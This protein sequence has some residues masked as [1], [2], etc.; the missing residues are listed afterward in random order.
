MKFV[1]IIVALAA[2]FLFPAASGLAQEQQPVTTVV[3]EPPGDNCPAGGVKVTVT[4]APEPDPEPTP[5][6]TETPT[7]DPTETATPEPTLTAVAAQAQEPEVYY[8]C[9]GQSGEPGPD[10]QDGPD[11]ANGLD[12]TDGV[13]GADGMDGENASD[14]STSPKS[15]V[16]ASAGVKWMRVPARFKRHRKVTVIANAKRRHVRVSARHKVRVDLR[17]AACGYYPVLVRKRGIRPLLRIWHLT[18][19]SARVERL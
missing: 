10:G 16:C 5:D 4:P 15:S 9:N 13:D 19:S 12:G 1:S 2:I 17:R 18:P 3:E 11:G 14:G 7:P 8:V 6:P